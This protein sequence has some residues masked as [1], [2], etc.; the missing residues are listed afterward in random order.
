[1]NYQVDQNTTASIDCEEIIVTPSDRFGITIEESQMNKLLIKSFWFAQRNVRHPLAVHINPLSNDFRHMKIVFNLARL[2]QLDF[3]SIALGIRSEWQLSSARVG[4]KS[5]Y[6]QVVSHES[7]RPA[8]FDYCRL[9]SSSAYTE[10]EFLVAL[11]KHANHMKNLNTE[12]EINIF[13]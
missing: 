11:V 5:N 7:F 12:V 6:I 1:M 8:P 3:I 13:N 2:K 10:E 4:F 9:V